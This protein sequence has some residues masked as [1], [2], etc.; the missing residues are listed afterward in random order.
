[1]PG[2]ELDGKTLRVYKYMVLHGRPVGVRELQRELGLSSPSVA[3]YH[4]G[5]LERLG[6]VE[7]TA[8]NKYVVKKLVKTDT[9]DF[10]VKLGRLAIP[11]YAFYTAFFAGLAALYLIAFAPPEL[12]EEYLLGLVAA[13]AAAAVSCYE[14]IRLYRRG[15]M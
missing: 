5:K 12:T 1:V 7:K 6:L 2:V 11:R 9:L 8:D 10:I 4:L 13:V 15:L 14:T 3:F